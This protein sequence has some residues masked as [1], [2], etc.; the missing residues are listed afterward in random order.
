MRG[1]GQ[2]TQEPS[3]KVTARSQPFPNP[4][5]FENVLPMKAKELDMGA[6]AESPRQQELP[7]IAHQP[8]YRIG[9]A[10]LG[11]EDAVVVI[12]GDQ[13]AIEHPVDGR[14]EGKAIAD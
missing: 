13:S 12:D 4:L 1:H 14:G 6:L 11:D 7:V 8:R 2:S 9:N 3:L 5:S 10:I